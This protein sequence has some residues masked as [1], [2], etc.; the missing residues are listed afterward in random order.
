MASTASR[1]TIRSPVCTSPSKPQWLTLRRRNE[2]GP[3]GQPA[4]QVAGTSPAVTRYTWAW[5]AG[6][7]EPGGGGVAVVGSRQAT[8]DAV[9]TRTAN[10]R[11]GLISRLSAARASTS[12]VR[13]RRVE[14]ELDGLSHGHRDTGQRHRPRCD[15]V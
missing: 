10:H 6:T 4:C 2:L 7:G 13:V 14:D 5:K 9:V 1:W 8:R 12:R 15:P 3:T 11:I